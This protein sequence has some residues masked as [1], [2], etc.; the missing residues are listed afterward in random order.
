MTFNKH[1]SNVF[2]KLTRA[3]YCLRRVTH[4]VSLKALITFKLYLLLSV[5][6]PPLVLRCYYELHIPDKPQ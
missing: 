3:N 5:S 1:I 2:A 6:L 4:L